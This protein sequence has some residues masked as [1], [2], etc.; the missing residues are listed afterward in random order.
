MEEQDRKKSRRRVPAGS[1]SA[2]HDRSE[3]YAYREHYDEREARHQ[4][5]QL[6]G[7]EPVEPK[8]CPH[9][10]PLD[11]ATPVAIRI[12]WFEPAILWLRR[13]LIAAACLR[14]ARASYDVGEY[15][16]SILSAQEGNGLVN[17]REPA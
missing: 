6:A 9:F 8:T 2:S 13:D 12:V 10:P 7:T 16:V 11:G 17:W 15:D 3:K 4:H 1:L 14:H 5:Q